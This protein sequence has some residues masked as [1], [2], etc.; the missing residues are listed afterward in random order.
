M[1]VVMRSFSR[2]LVSV[3]CDD[4]FVPASKELT[5]ALVLC[6]HASSPADRWMHGGIEWLQTLRQKRKKA[7]ADVTLQ[8]LIGTF[9]SKC[10]LNARKLTSL[11]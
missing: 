7:V 3:S 4:T 2:H 11:I 10:H 5:G 1:F 8:V 9:S 6:Q